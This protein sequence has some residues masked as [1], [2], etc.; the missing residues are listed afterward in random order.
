MC[1]RFFRAMEG[2][3]VG[4]GMHTPLIGNVGSI[5]SCGE[6]AGGG[7]TVI[8]ERDVEVKRGTTCHPTPCC[9]P[10]GCPMGGADQPRHRLSP[11]GETHRTRSV[12][13]GNVVFV[14]KKK[15]PFL[16][17][18]TIRIPSAKRIPWLCIRTLPSCPEM[19]KSLFQDAS[20][21]DCRVRQL[22]ECKEFITIWNRNR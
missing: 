16:I 4:M 18:C 2:L 11:H 21:R 5:A 10:R 19:R 13:C 3:S 6:L 22:I 8:S 12:S 7:T 1:W 9:I 15:K 17:S 20:T 14:V